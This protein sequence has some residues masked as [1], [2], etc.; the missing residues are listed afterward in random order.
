MRYPHPTFLTGREK[1]IYFGGNVD[2]FLKNPENCEF[3]MN[4][5]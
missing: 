4:N 2:T 3:L 1:N 5:E